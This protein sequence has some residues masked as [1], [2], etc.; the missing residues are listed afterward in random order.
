MRA[1]LQ[2]HLATA[3]RVNNPVACSGVVDF[4]NVCRVRKRDKGVVVWITAD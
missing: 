1:C 4:A 3:A 2:A